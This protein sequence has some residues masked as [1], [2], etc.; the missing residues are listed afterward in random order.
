VWTFCNK[1]WC[2]LV[3]SHNQLFS[4]GACCNNL[5]NNPDTPSTSAW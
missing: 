5:A 3:T 4:W 1:R 2:E